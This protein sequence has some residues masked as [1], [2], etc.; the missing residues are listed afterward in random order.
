MFR[1]SGFLLSGVVGAGE[2]SDVRLHGFRRR[3]PERLAVAP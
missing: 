2:Q 1:S 3:I